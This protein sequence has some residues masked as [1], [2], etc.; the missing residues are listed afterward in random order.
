MH[1]CCVLMDISD[2]CTSSVRKLTVT[3][4]SE[5]GSILF[6]SRDIGKEANI[7]SVRNEIYQHVIKKFTNVFCFEKLVG[8]QF[9]VL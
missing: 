8:L 4:Y 2:E 3:G 1:E 7:M 6:P 5:E 9:Y